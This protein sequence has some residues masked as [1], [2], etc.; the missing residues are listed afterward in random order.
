MEMI[1]KGHNEQYTKSLDFGITFVI[2]PQ[3]HK[4]EKCLTP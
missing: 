2:A 1:K 4:R 3:I